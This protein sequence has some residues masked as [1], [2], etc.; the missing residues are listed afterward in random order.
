MRNRSELLF[1]YDIVNNNPNGDPLDSNKP[2]IDEETSINIVTDVR[3]KRTIRDY[4]NEYKNEEI[5]VRE[6]KDNKGNV[7]D[8]KTRASNFGSTKDEVSNNILKQCIDIRL[9]GGTIPLSKGSVTFTGPVQFNMGRSLHRVCLRRIR[10]TG[11]FASGENKANK[12]FRE[13]YI[14]PYS[15][16]SFYGI[17]NEHAG[18]K[19]N[20][21]E[22]DIN[23]LI[24]GMWKGT[25]NLI[26]RSKMGQLPRLLLKINYKE[27]DFCIGGL[28]NKIKLNKKVEDEAI[29]NHRDYDL[30]LSELA[31]CIDKNKSKIE[32][33]EYL[34]DE[35]FKLSINN[36]VKDLEYILPDIELRKINL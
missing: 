1:L 9:F 16:I 29:R 13:E 5:F 31:K 22:R 6:I 23:L 35:E 25:K 20:L 33:I 12:T 7:Q 2:R 28:L 14:L 21:S 36:E 4:L 34:I 3:L 10:G 15:L 30:D 19:T 18:K 24:E 8:G 26:S 27:N 32:N 17:I 11:A